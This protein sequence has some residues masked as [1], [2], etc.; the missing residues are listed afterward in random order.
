[1]DGDDDGVDDG[2][3]LTRPSMQSPQSLV[4]PHGHPYKCYTEVLRFV[5]VQL[6]RDVLR[7]QKSL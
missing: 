5:M 1:M 6:L 7:H 2:S 3:P 4:S